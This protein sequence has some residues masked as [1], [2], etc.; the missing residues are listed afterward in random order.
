MLNALSCPDH[1]TFAPLAALT[2]TYIYTQL[3]CKLTI[4]KN[5][6]HSNRVVVGGGGV[7]Y[8][9]M[10][11]T[12]TTTTCA[13]F[14]SALLHGALWGSKRISEIVIVAVRTA[15]PVNA[16]TASPCPPEDPASQTRR[17]GAS[18][19]DT[20]VTGPRVTVPQRHPSRGSSVTQSA[21]SSRSH[22]SRERDLWSMIH[23]I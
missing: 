16:G 20:L 17:S 15:V 1:C 21:Q 22:G 19:L 13:L 8:R 23:V 5:D 2:C 18:L 10:A 4:P 9:R 14:G 11:L 3:V 12:K 7:H 6:P